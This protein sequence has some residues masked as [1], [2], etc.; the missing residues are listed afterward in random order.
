HV[1]LL[2]ACA[3]TAGAPFVTAA[4]PAAPRTV[5]ASGT[6]T[7]IEEDPGHEAARLELAASQRAAAM[8]PVARQPSGN[9]SVKITGEL[10]QWHKVTLELAGPFA[11]ESDASPNPFTDLR[12]DVTFTHES[13]TPRYVVP[14]YFAADGNAANTSANAGTVWRAHLS[15]D[16]PGKWTYRVAFTQGP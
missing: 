11:A 3:L 13:G 15:P 7:A 16:K 12:L 2:L 1:L 8:K 6:V 9:G 14:G 5:G 10:K 4:A